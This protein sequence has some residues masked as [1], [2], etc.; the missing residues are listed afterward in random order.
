MNWVGSVV[1]VCQSRILFNQ[2]MSSAGDFSL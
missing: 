1:S 2:T